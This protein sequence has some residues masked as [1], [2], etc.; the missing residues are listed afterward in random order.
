MK[1]L[2]P[3]YALIAVSTTSCGTD[4]KKKAPPSQSDVLEEKMN[5]LYEE[6]TKD[7]LSSYEMS[8]KL[9]NYFMA[10]YGTLYVIEAKGLHSVEETEKGLE[11][12]EEESLSLGEV[13]NLE[14]NLKD[15]AGSLNHLYYSLTLLT[16]S[17]KETYE[18]G[19]EK[20][21]DVFED[22]LLCE[23]GVDVCVGVMALSYRQV[24]GEYS[25]WSHP[26]AQSM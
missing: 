4:D 22:Y 5:A 11:K 23:D 1:F 9:K 20:L 8:E 17:R 10:K 6:K 25:L 12:I 18:E 15:E 19:K 21:E 7:L 26:K 14:K 24:I 16:E 2:L 13:F 3:L